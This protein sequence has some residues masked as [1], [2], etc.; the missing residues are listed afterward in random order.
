MGERTSP[1]QCRHDLN[2]ATC[3]KKMRVRLLFSSVNVSTIVTEDK[4]REETLIQ[5]SKD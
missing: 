4:K 5:M 1:R 2:D 3:L